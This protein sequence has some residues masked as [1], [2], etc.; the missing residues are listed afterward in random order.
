MEKLPDEED[1]IPKLEMWTK[2]MQ[3]TLFLFVKFI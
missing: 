2:S 1:P 3:I